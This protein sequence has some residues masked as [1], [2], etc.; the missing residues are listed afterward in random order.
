M[1]NPLR[2]LALITRLALIAPLA[3]LALAL[4]CID[5]AG[6]ATAGEGDEVTIVLVGD[7]GL[8]RNSQRVEPRGVHKFGFQTWANTT[9][10]I[11]KVEEIL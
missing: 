5:P 4:I 11:A 1:M 2:P 7:V 9:E 8:N 10:L 6:V 3:V